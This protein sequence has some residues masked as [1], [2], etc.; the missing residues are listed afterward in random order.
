MPMEVLGNFED[1]ED[2][3]FFEPIS[4]KK[5]EKI[6]S[7]RHPVDPDLKTRFSMKDRITVNDYE[8]KLSD[9]CFCYAAT[10][11]FKQKGKSMAKMMK[12]GKKV[13]KIERPKTMVDMPES[14]SDSSDSSGEDIMTKGLTMC[15]I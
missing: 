14:G 3:N 9:A 5:L 12:G 1:D 8:A 6:I 13:A 15:S 2:I 4:Y 10:Q 7:Q 11:Y